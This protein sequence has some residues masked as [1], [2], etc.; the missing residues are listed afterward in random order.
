MMCVVMLFLLLQSSSTYVGGSWNQ[1]NFAPVEIAVDDTTAYLTMP[2]EGPDARG[3]LSNRGV[4]YDLEA[5]RIAT[6]VAVGPD[7]VAVVAH[8]KEVL[9]FQ[10]KDSSLRP[11]RR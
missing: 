1:R 11:E 6:V 9:V 5:R 7:Q 3:S 4:A 2:L 10:R 8:K